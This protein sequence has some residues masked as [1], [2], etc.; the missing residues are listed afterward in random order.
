MPDEREVFSGMANDSMTI[1]Q[2]RGGLDDLQRSLTIAH[3]KEAMP[4][5]TATQNGSTQPVANTGSQPQSDTKK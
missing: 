1:N 5:P 2:I 3:L 4:A